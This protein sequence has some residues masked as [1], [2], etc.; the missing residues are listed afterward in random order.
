ME[1]IGVAILFA[2]LVV[3]IRNIAALVERVRQM[4]SVQPAAHE[5]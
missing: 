1:L 3:F 2:W 4:E 5:Q